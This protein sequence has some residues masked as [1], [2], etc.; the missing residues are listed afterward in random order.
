MSSLVSLDSIDRT[1]IR[2]EWLDDG[3]YY[4]VIDIL[5]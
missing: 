5:M 1:R 2:R 4:S 3:W